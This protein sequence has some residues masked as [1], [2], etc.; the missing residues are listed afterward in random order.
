MPDEL[1]QLRAFYRR[2]RAIAYAG[3]CDA[4]N[5]PDRLIDLCDQFKPRVAG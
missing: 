3:D 5:V 2:V 1:E 4:C